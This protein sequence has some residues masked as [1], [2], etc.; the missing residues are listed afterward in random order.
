MKQGFLPHLSSSL[1]PRPPLHI[2]SQRQLLLMVYCRCHLIKISS[3]LAKDILHKFRLSVQYQTFLKSDHHWKNL[4]PSFA[5][6]KSSTL[7]TLCLCPNM[8]LYYTKYHGY[9]NITLCDNGFLITSLPPIL[10]H[11]HLWCRLCI[12]TDHVK[13]HVLLKLLEVQM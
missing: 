10:P 5:E 9:G 8:F 2:F 7:G 11:P 6:V 4:A 12:S 13:S 1:S 3:I